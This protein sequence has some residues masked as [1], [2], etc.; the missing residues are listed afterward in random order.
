MD[1]LLT[2]VR[3][4]SSSLKWLEEVLL[5]CLLTAMILL[6]CLQI[7]LRDVFGGGIVWADPLLRYMVIW[8]GLLG[9]V[10]ATRQEKHVVIDLASHLF[11]EN[12]KP[13]LLVLTN[14]FSVLVCAGLTYA[15]TIFV[16]NEAAY[17]G[18][19][20]VLG[21]E[22]WVLNLIFPAA[23]GIISLRFLSVT[24]GHVIKIAQS[25]SS[26]GNDS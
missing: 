21:I 10:V 19:R 3:K 16:Y 9:A 24:I 7:V 17:G 23:F 25:M 2:P 1:W 14:F 5:C 6:A 8:S 15:G 13:W 11:P 20:Q 18:D 12:I 4:A 26:P 22:S